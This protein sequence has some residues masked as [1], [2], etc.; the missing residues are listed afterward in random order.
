MP[1]T[2]RPH[3]AHTLCTHE[4][5]IRGISFRFNAFEFS[6]LSS[7]LSMYYIYILSTHFPNFTLLVSLV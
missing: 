1:W 3:L 5:Q 6:T 2:I 7:M 4:Q